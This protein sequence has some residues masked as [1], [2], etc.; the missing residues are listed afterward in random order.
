MVLVELKNG[1]TYNGHLVSCDNWM[2]INLRE[3]I[4]TSRV[5]DMVKDEMVKQGRSRGTGRPGTLFAS[6]MVTGRM[7]YSMPGCR[8]SG[9]LV[10]FLTYVSMTTMTLTAVNRYFRVVKPQLYKTLFG[11]RR[12][13]IILATLWVLIAA[14][15]LYPTVFNLA[16]LTFN[17]AL[18]SCAYTFVS[19]GAEIAFTLTVVCVFVVFCLS[20]VCVCYYQVSKAI[21]KHNADVFLSLQGLSAHEIKLS[22]VLFITV[23]AFAMC[24]LPTFGVILIIRVILGKAPHALAVVIPFPVSDL[25]CSE[26]LI[27]GALSPPFRR[28]FRRLLTFKQTVHLTDESQRSVVPSATH[29][30]GL[31]LEQISINHQSQVDVSNPGGM[32]LT[33]YNIIS[34][35]RLPGCRCGI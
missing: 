3:V 33:K 15:V 10:H 30:R 28:E 29:E 25:Q 18:S 21:S 32:G 1:E 12:S 20:L 31:A 26:P 17:P 4:C 35:R 8:L 9:F 27:Y 19:K 2:N 13:W 5:I 11:E 34:S 24:W 22:K 6:T 23:F 16:E 7:I 14:F